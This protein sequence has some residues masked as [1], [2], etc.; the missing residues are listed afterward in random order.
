MLTV[1]EKRG[2]KKNNEMKEEEGVR[3]TACTIAVRNSN[4]ILV[5]SPKQESTRETQK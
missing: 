5:G 3:Q 1:S 2:L 4:K